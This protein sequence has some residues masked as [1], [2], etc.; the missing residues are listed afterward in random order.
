MKYVK[1]I[2]FS[3]FLIMRNLKRLYLVGTMENSEEEESWK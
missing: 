2:V 1:S 3:S